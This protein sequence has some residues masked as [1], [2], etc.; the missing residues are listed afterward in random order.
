MGKID[1][2]YSQY[3][4]I[5]LIDEKADR[6]EVERLKTGKLDVASFEVYKN[7]VQTSDELGNINLVLRK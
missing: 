5:Q 1:L 6:I 3:Q 2:K 4:I 7:D